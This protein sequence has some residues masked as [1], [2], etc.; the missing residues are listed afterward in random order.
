[1]ELETL[2]AFIKTNLAN[3][4]IKL[5]KS[6]ANTPI[7]FKQ[8]SDSFFLLYV[9]YRDLNNFTINNGYLLPLIGELL[10]KLRKIK[11][12]IQLNFTRVYHQIRIQQVENCVQDLI[13]PF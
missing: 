12:F 7:L 6:P 3:R 10:D 2:K 4:F 1:M 8:K 11:R 5:S 9:N 13:R